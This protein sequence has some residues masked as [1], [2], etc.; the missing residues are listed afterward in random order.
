MISIFFLPALPPY[1]I[2]FRSR[3]IRRNYDRP[4]LYQPRR[5]WFH[6]LL[7]VNTQSLMLHSWIFGLLIINQLQPLHIVVYLFILENFVDTL[8]PSQSYA[9]K[10]FCL[11]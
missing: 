9:R 2:Y 6:R 11:P 7:T 10:S 1:W 3:D 4:Y 8:H 5:P